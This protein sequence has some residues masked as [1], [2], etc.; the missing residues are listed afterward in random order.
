M[1]AS[2]FQ[3]SLGAFDKYGLGA[4]AS[5]RS[6]QR[7]GFIGLGS[8][9]STRFA[10]Y[11]SVTHTHNYTS[12]LLLVRFGCSFCTTSRTLDRLDWTVFHRVDHKS[13][14]TNTSYINKIPWIFR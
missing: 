9:L 5:L 14:P 2:N 12:G 6:H 7:H 13:T 4:K 8:S 10:V 3:R 1:T 11:L